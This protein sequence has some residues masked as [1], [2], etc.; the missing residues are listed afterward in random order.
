[1][2]KNETIIIDR[3]GYWIAEIQRAG[4]SWTVHGPGYPGAA[5]CESV[6]EACRYV[7]QVA[8]AWLRV[9]QRDPETYLLGGGEV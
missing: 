2:N 5:E 3:D 6:W 7:D 1:M 8:S 4:D 9:A